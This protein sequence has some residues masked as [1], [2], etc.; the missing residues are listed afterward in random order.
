[1]S[2]YGYGSDQHEQIQILI[3]NNSQIF[4]AC[5]KVGAYVTLMNYAYSKHELIAALSSTK[6]KVLL[7]TVRT[8]RYDYMSSLQAVEN[9]APSLERIIILDDISRRDR[10]VV[11]PG[12]WL[13]YQALLDTATAISIDWASRE[14]IECNE[15][16][17]LQFTS[18]STGAPKAAA[19]THFGMMNSARYLSIQMKVGEQDIITIPV[20]LF[21][22]FG[23][24]MGE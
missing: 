5:S 14:S 19:L 16:L 13:T 12:S 6:S 21:H 4:L 3:V 11:L 17:N 15:I 8:S 20:P 7:T 22:A 9:E 24:V 2:R 23:L 18:G 10:D 1:M